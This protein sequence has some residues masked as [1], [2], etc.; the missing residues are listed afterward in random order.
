MIRENA[1]MS[2]WSPNLRN[3]CALL[4]DLVMIE[5]WKK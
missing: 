2:A 1:Q 4:I 5:V 3:A